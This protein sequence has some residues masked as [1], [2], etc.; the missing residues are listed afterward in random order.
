MV[1]QVHN[2]SV[3]IELLFQCTSAYVVTLPDS[4]LVISLISDLISPIATAS[5]LSVD[6]VDIARRSSA[7]RALNN[8]EL[9]K[10]SLH[11]HTAVARLPGIS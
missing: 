8:G 7:R 4:G 9:A 5:R 6:C 10:T 11:T 3:V 1:L 2:V